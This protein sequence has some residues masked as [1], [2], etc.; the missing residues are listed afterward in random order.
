MCGGG[1]KRLPVLRLNV[2]PDNR[3]AHKA[4]GPVLCRRW[5]S[6]STRS[7]QGRVEQPSVCL[8]L[9]CLKL[10]WTSC[11]ETPWG[12]KGP[13]E[14][15]PTPGFLAICSSIRALFFFTPREH[16]RVCVAGR[17]GAGCCLCAGLEEL[18]NA[19]M[20]HVCDAECAGEIKSIILSHAWRLEKCSLIEAN[21]KV[22]KCNIYNQTNRD[23]LTN[24]NPT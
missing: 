13:W 2:P 16:K 23:F 5:A 12:W 3:R 1:V 14:P 19:F 9:K 11:G 4:S 24:L 18:L 21:V 20:T 22:Q 17:W 7:R 6:A 8:M 10:D 15:P